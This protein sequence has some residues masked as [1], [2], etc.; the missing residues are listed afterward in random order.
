M[1]IIRNDMLILRTDEVSELLE[2]YEEK[3][4]EDFVPF[5]CRD[6]RWAGDKP[7]AAF[8]VETLR[9]ALEKNEPTRYKENPFEF[10]GH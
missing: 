9:E 5:N 3:F 8:Y 2:A 4:C 7:A 1:Y 10:F 6:F